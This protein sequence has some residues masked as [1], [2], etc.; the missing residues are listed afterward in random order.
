MNEKSENRICQNCKQSFTI[1]VDDFSFYEKIKVPPPTFCPEC[2]LIRKMATFNI[3][4]LYYRKCN[5]CEENTVSIFNSNSP[6]IVWCFDC[7]FSDKFNPSSYNLD[8]DFSVNFFI[9]YEKLR[10]TIPIL[11]LEQ[12]G[13][14][15][16]GCEYANYTYG[17]KNIYLSHNVAKSEN[18]YYSVFVNRDNKMCFDSLSFR[19]DEL[20]YEVVDSN[21][22][23]DC[24]YLTKSDSCISSKFLFNCV[25]CQNCFMS[26]NQRNQNYI[27][28]NKKLS[29]DEYNKAIK[30]EDLFS[31]NIWKKMIDEYEKLRNNTIVRFARIVNSVNCTGDIIENSKNCLSSFYIWGSENLRYVTYSVNALKDSYDMLDSGR[32]ERMY[33]S[34][35]SGRGNYEIGFSSRTFGTTYSYYCE[36]C[37][38]CKN[39][40]GCIGLRKKQYCIFNKQYTKEEYEELVPKI[41]KQMNDIPYIDKNNCQYRFGEFFPIEI[42]PFA[43][44]ET[45]AYEQFPL[46]KE[47]VLEKNY[48]WFDEL[49]RN[50]KYTMEASDI[51]DDI[52]RADKKILNETIHCEHNDSCSHQ[53]TNAFRILPEELQFY[54]RMNLPIPR[55]CPNCRYFI[56]LGRT[57]PWRLW[58]RHCMKEGCQNEFETSYAPE[59][60]EIIYCERCYQNEVY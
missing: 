33:E 49:D 31:Y 32:G 24:S 34:I 12:S 51:P 41:I 8:Y 27:F 16:G 57:S 10:K 59:R 18:I 42:S 55:I 22:N 9:Q 54:R 26:S 5:N 46:S 15:S 35:C 43:Y 45:M 36:G 50:H 19:E 37:I 2:R 1:E 6:H 28:R 47:Q 3:R 21:H 20:C 40:F 25:N 44:N 48:R 53:C 11:C 29:K 4:N 17:S 23:Y 58:Y 52:S 14:N 13:N 30:K 38:D 60:P 7:Y 39:C 56:R